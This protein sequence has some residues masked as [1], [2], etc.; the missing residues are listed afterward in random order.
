MLSSYLRP[1]HC[2]NHRCTAAHLAAQCAPGSPQSAGFLYILRYLLEKGAPPDARARGGNCPMHLAAAAG[3]VEAVKLLL[4]FK[5]DPFVLNEQGL[6]P[7]QAST[8]CVM[9]AGGQVPIVC[10][11]PGLACVQRGAEALGEVSCAGVVRR[12]PCLACAQQCT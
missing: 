4:H 12:K 8:V 1:F 10:L 5:A 7:L 2:P 11:T 3:G 6:S 9:P